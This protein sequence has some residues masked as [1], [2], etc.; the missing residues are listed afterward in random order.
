MDRSIRSFVR[1]RH[2]LPSD[3]S[4]VVL[5]APS[6]DGGIAITRLF[7]AIPMLR[8]KRILSNRRNDDTIIQTL[9]D[10]VILK[11]STPRLYDEY[12]FVDNTSIHKYHSIYLFNS[13]DG[14]GF[15]QYL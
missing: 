12:T 9:S 8:L 7:L 4:L 10:I 3:T 14:F 5:Y 2:R 15:Y 1:R 11:L 6:S 13:V